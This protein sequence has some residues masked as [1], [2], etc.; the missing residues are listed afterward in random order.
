[1]EFWQ[2]RIRKAPH[3]QSVYSTARKLDNR[4]IRVYAA[5][6]STTPSYGI[7]TSKKLGNAVARN[8]ARRQFKEFIRLHSSYFDQHLELVFVLK[9]AYCHSPFWKKTSVLIE[10]L[11]AYDVM[12]KESRCLKPS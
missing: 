6:A 9:P 7:I 1:M 8:R 11:K 3:F 4:F 12:S 5:P 10:F 2:S